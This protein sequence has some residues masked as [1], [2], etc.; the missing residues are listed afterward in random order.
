MLPVLA[1][2]RRHVYLPDALARLHV[3]AHG[4][5]DRLKVTDHAAC[6]PALLPLCHIRRQLAHFVSGRKIHGK[7]QASG[8]Y[9]NFR[10]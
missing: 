6:P 4:P 5:Q 9:R 1:D 2:A 3:R 10:T 7:Q 8:K